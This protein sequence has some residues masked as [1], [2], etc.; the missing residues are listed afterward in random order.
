M[1]KAPLSIV[2]MTSWE[3]KK[4]SAAVGKTLGGGLKFGGKKKILKYE[5]EENILPPAD[6]PVL[7]E[8]VNQAPWLGHFCWFLESVQSSIISWQL[9]DSIVIY[10]EPG[11]QNMHI[12]EQLHRIYH[13]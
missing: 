13:T 10:K 4:F 1:T 2:C 8:T 12:K 7:Q 9:G 3:G 5:K 11:P 6:E